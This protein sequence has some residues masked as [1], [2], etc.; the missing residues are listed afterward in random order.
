MFVE[1]LFGLLHLLLVDQAHVPQTAVGKAV[2]DGA[3]QPTR[4]VVIDQ[5]PDVRPQGGEQ[6]HQRDTH[7]AVDGRHVGRRGDDQFGGERDKRTLDRHEDR[8]PEVIEVVEDRLDEFCGFHTGNLR[9]LL[10]ESK[11]NLPIFRPALP[12][13]DEKSGKNTTFDLWQHCGTVLSRAAFCHTV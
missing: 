6:H 3:S 4:Q 8:D 12:A 10:C 11:K 7:L 2:N 9:F 13:R 5:R 1:V